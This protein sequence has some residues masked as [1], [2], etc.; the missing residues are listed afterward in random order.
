MTGQCQGK[1]PLQDSKRSRKNNRTYLN[2]SA[3][4]CN[5]GCKTLL[6]SQLLIIEV[7]F[8]D[9]YQKTA[10]VIGL[11]FLK[12]TFDTYTQ[13]KTRQIVVVER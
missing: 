10:N 11:S 4:Q 7:N 6:K 2:S 12:M 13:T 3:G 9:N 5:E 8:N 1:G